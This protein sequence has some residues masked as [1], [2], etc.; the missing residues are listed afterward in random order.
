MGASKVI[1][2]LLKNRRDHSSIARVNAESAP[3]H[4]AAY[5][6]LEGCRSR[7]TKDGGILQDHVKAPSRLTGF[8]ESTY[9]FFENSWYNGEVIRWTSFDS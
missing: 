2:T 6:T 8:R 4:I 3:I 9:S 5:G 1:V 7:G